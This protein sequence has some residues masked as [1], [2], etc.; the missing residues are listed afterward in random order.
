MMVKS[1]GVTDQ[2]IRPVIH[3]CLIFTNLGPS[4]QEPAPV[5]LFWKVQRELTFLKCNSLPVMAVYICYLI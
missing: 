2:N 4:S 1:V 3:L 5:P